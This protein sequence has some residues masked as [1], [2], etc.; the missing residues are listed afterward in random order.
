MESLSFIQWCLDNL[1][2]WTITFLMMIESSFIP[3][4][5]EI[6]IIPAAYKA[7]Y[8][9]LN[10]YLVVIFGTLGADLGAIINYY[11]ARWIGRPLVYKFAN[12]RI[13]HIC[14][15]DQKKVETAERYF[16]KHGSIS[17]L[18]G[19]L[20]PAVRQLISIPAGLARMKVSKFILFT[21]LGAMCWNIVLAAIGYGFHAVI[22]EDELISKVQMYSH[23]ILYILI[24]ICVFIVGFL[25][26]KGMKKLK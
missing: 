15:L 20:I 16:D 26:Y 24:A 21:T 23:E 12:S 10:M 8:G 14:L 7:A 1:N 4:P 19:R 17:T 13:G 18:I 22:P 11:L 5:S 6:V 25:I 3:F 9:E 2:Y